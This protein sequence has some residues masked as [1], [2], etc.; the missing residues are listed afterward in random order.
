MNATFVFSVATIVLSISA[1]QGSSERNAVATTF[2]LPTEAPSE[3]QG[4]PTSP[5]GIHYELLGEPQLG[6]PLE[7]RI[8]SRSNVIVAG[9]EV[10][11]RGDEQ[12]V[13]SAV[14]QS[15]AVEPV[16][17][18]EPMIRTVTVTPLQEGLHYLSVTVQGVINGQTQADSVT[19]PIRVGDVEH[20]TEP[21]GTLVTDDAG[22]V[23][24]SLPARDN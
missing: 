17:A 20:R 14:S 21:M 23:I 3:S 9:L 4:K 5:I 12:L 18:N 2:A 6:Q 8:T 16:E 15:F 11:V 1:C 24:I 22:E 10:Q 7:I 19:I 13:V